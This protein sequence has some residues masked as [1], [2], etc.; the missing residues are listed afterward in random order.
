MKVRLE[1]LEDK[2]NNKAKALMND[3]GQKYNS[4]NDLVAF[5]PD[6]KLPLLLLKLLLRI[7]GFLI[8]LAISPFALIGLILAF[9]M[10]G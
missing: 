2:E 4:F 1:D 9:L 6:D 5:R 8:M 7:V 3:L 10:A